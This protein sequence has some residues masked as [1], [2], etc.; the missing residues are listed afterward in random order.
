[1]EKMLERIILKLDKI[2]NQVGEKALWLV[3]AMI[4][5]QFSVVLLSKLYGLSFTQ[6]D[7]SIWYLNG[8]IFMLGAAYTLLHDRHVRVDIIYAEAGAKYKALVDLFGALFFILPVAFLTY[9]LSWNFVLDSWFNFSTGQWIIER[10]DGSLDSLP[11][12]SLF[13]TIIWVYSFLLALSALSL[14]AKAILSLSGHHQTYNPAMHTG[15]LTENSNYTA[16]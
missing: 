16:Q 9:G 11:L 13:K 6:L 10:A 8:L 1:M 14:A 12:L 4:L 7:E 3:L 15:K 2:N 5:L